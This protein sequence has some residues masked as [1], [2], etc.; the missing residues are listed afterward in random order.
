MEEKKMTKNIIQRGN[1]GKETEKEG[2]KFLKKEW[3]RN[4]MKY[5]KRKNA[6]GT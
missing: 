2:K 3:R 5:K 6:K 1:R 4:E